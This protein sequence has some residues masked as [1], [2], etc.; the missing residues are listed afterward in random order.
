MSARL[1]VTL[2]S[3]DHRCHRPCPYR[4]L[5]PASLF[6]PFSLASG[7]GPCACALRT[8]GHVPSNMNM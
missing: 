5:L 4:T 6:V 3:P 2:P 8:T 7:V 1:L